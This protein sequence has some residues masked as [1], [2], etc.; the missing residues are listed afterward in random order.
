MLMLL[1]HQRHSK[2]KGHQ[3]YEHIGEDSRDKLPK[4]LG[5]RAWYKYCLLAFANRYD[6]SLGWF[7]ISDQILQYFGKL[8]RPIARKS[9]IDRYRQFLRDWLIVIYPKHAKLLQ[10]SLSQILLMIISPND[11]SFSISTWVLSSVAPPEADLDAEQHM[12]PNKISHVSA[13]WLF[14]LFSVDQLSS[15]PRLRLPIPMDSSYE[16]WGWTRIVIQESNRVPVEVSVQSGQAEQL[17]LLLKTLFS[18]HGNIYKCSLQWRSYS[19]YMLPPSRSLTQ[20]GYDPNRCALWPCLNQRMTQ[21]PP[22]Q[23]FSIVI[24]TPGRLLHQR[25]LYS[26]GDCSCSS[27]WRMWSLILSFLLKPS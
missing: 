14:S 7:V 11:R 2:W 18:Q 1:R 23:S 21:L 20:R 3:L 8:L 24:K 6:P 22:L 15:N 5:V 10:W 17:I 26:R 9:F 27:V 13:T 16:L 19:G 25:A 12:S 4:H